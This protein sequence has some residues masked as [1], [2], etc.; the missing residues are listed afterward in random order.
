MTDYGWL[1]ELPFTAQGGGQLCYVALS[2]GPFPLVRLIGR[3]K[4]VEQIESPFTFTPDSN[5]ALRFAR[6]EDAEAFM[7]KFDRFILHGL[8]T[9]HAWENPDG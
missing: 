7:A 8:V 2:D 6:R 4:T 1:I 3:R 9:E 5:A